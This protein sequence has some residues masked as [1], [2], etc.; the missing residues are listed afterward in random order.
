M[1]EKGKSNVVTNHFE[2]K[3]FKQVTTMIIQNYLGKS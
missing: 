3:K 1:V 2:K